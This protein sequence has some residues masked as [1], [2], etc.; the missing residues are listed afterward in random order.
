MKENAVNKNTRKST[1][2]WLSVWNEWA[3]IRGYRKELESYPPTELN[4]C[5]QKFYAEIRNKKGEEYEPDSLKV[6]LAALDRYLKEKNYSHS[7]VRDRE[8]SESKKVLEGKARQLRQQGLGKR[9]NTAKALTAE[10][11]ETLWQA[12]KLGNSSPAALTNT[13]WW[14]LTQHFG[15]RGRQEHHEMTVEDF[16]MGF[17]D[18]G[19]EFV[20]FKENPTKTRQGGLYIKRRPQLPK[21]FATGNER[22]PV[23][24]FK[25]YLSHRP[26]ELRSTG[27]FYLANLPQPK[28]NIWYKRQNLGVNS[29]DKIMK[30]MVADSPLKESTKKLTNHSARK[31][32]VKK[33]RANN[34]ERSSIINVT[35]HAS[36]QSL[37]DYDEGNE[38]EQRQI[39]NLI[40]NAAVQGR[41]P[42][43]VQPLSSIFPAN[44]SSSQQ[45]FQA[46]SSER[47]FISG[48]Q[49]FKCSVT[50]N[51]GPGPS[52]SSPTLRK[53]FKRVN[54]LE[55]DSDSQ[56]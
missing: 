35:G 47:Q 17:D 52:C 30:T 44:L 28:N 23:A 8:F 7:I 36:E 54:I 12:Q 33:L 13:M 26:T 20:T 10:E 34:V 56:E 18:Q 51:V 38:N 24:F 42:Q 27:A 14:L 15:L 29:I 48:N 50:F 43:S 3:S 40:S 32:L 4:D 25:E 16:E 9:P 55:S 6:M 2:D 53:K 1:N 21:M 11:E 46:C 45:Q 31:T 39:S 41:N 22:C 37:N 19:V 49:F 5:L